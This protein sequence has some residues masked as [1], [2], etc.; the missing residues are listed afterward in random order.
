MVEKFDKL[1]ERIPV[2]RKGKW[3]GGWPGDRWDPYWE[4]TR[5]E[6]RDIFRCIF[7]SR[8]L[9]V[10]RNDRKRDRALGLLKKAGLIRY[11]RSRGWVVNQP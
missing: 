11:V 7:D 1:S 8:P 10:F 9:P 6:L 4:L 3:A 2:P 5:D